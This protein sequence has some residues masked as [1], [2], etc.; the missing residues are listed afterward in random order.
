MSTLT[1]S[2]LK[3]DFSKSGNLFKNYAMAD[4]LVSKLIFVVIIII[5]FFLLLRLII[6]VMSYMFSPKKSPYIIKGL[7]EGNKLVIKP[8]NPRTKKA[9]TL[10]RSKNENDG[11]E[12][13]Y[14]V[15]LNIDYRMKHTTY[16]HIFSKGSFTNTDK[17]GIYYPNNCPGLYFNSTQTSANDEDTDSHN[18]LNELVFVMNTYNNPQETVVVS[19]IPLEKWINVVIRVT[20]NI[21]DVYINGII[22]KR[23]ILSGVPKQNYEDIIVCGGSLNGFDGQLSNLRYYDYSLNALEI[24]AI[25]L[26]GPNLKAAKTKGISTPPYLSTNWYLNN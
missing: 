13:S 20:D 14:S 16:N 21:V 17:M 22:T 4:S 1:N 19:N 5:L 12:F 23:H 18:I 26:E 25:T 7:H 10:Y 6:I 3:T 9:M 11:I 15:W 8:Q 2:S 24:N